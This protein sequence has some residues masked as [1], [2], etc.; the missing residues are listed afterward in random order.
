MGKGYKIT[1]S[2]LTIMILLT[3]TLGTSYSYYSISV[4]QPGATPNQMVSTC[5]N[6]TLNG[7]NNLNLTASG[8]GVTYPMNESTALTKITPYKMTITNTCTTS[9]ASANA[10]FDLSLNTFTATPS[11]LTPYLMYKL[12]KTSAPAAT[13]TAALL[14][15]KKNTSFNNSL[16]A[17]VDESFT[18][19]SNQSIA[20]G[21]SVTYDLYLWITESATTAINDYTFKGKILLYS[22]M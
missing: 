14:S 15:T 5:F 19:L 1:L 20:P 8:A 17:G 16:L 9:N 3:I 6:V 11:N 12:N 2:V 7:T 10:K 18:L 22:Y 21:T 13:G 4:E